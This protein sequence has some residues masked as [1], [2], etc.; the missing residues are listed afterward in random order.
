MKRIIGIAIILALAVVAVAIPSLASISLSHHSQQNEA[1]AAPQRVT[2]FAQNGPRTFGQLFQK[3]K[4]MVV[5]YNFTDGAG[6]KSCD[7]ISYFV[8]PTF[9]TDGT[10]AYKVNLTETHASDS[11]VDSAIVWVSPYSNTILQVFMGGT[12]WTGSA[13]QK[14]SGVLSMITT[15]SWLSLLNSSTFTVLKE[16]YTAKAGQTQVLATTYSALPNFTEYEGLT[17]VVGTIPQAG[18]MQIV[19]SSN[20]FVPG[21]GYASFRVLSLGLS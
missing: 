10:L 6:N 12:Y 21:N 16:N 2:V 3:I 19:L 15:N 17:I 20:Y 9:M 4:S 5:E 11:D 8:T 13:A 14:E 1:P 18:D 7:I